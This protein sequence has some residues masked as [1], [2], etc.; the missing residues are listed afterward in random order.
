MQGEHTKKNK[1]ESSLQRNEIEECRL[2][3]IES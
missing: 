2:I 1:L 3:I